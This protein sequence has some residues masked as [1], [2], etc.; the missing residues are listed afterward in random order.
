MPVSVSFWFDPATDAA[1]RAVW[2]KLAEAGISTYMHE[3]GFR[4][5]ITL[6]AYDDVDPASLQ[7]VLRDLTASVRAFSIEL[8]FLGQFLAP[9]GTIFLAPI[10][11]RPMLSLQAAI[12][13]ALAGSGQISAGSQ[14]DSDRWVPHVTLGTDLSTDKLSAAF[15]VCRQVALPWSAR[16]D[17]LGLVDY[18]TTA[19]LG[20]IP[21]C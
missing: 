6:V 4:P 18:V 17:R 21:L 1:V 9:A 12:V 13:D 16:V 11:T 2:R 19:E 10:V 3:C 20:E 15:E 7:R 14:Y 5:H 8:Y